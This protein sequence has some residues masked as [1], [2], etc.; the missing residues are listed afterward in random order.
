MNY[1]VHVVLFYIYQVVTGH[2][3]RVPV[4]PN[5][6]AD[7]LG[8]LP[9]HCI[10]QL[11][12]SRAFTKHKVPIKDWIYRQITGSTLPIHPVLPALLEVYTQ[13]ILV[14]GT[15]TVGSTKVLL[16]LTNEPLTDEEVLGVFKT[17]HNKH[18]APQ[19]LILYYLLLYEDN[20]LSNYRNL[21]QLGKKVKTY[22]GKLFSQIPIKF[23]LQEAQ[24]HQNNCGGK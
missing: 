13:S 19:L 17:F 6:N 1:Y 22:S 12:K 8:F 21:T 20:R 15:S 10:Y 16:E 3:V 2:A 14:P 11:I 24:R 5:L 7:Q 23:L 9:V 18:L 4:T